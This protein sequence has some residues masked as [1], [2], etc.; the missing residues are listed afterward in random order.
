[1]VL[2]F[3]EKELAFVKLVLEAEGYDDNLKGWILDTMQGENEDEEES[4]YAGAAD[5]VIN[6]VS[7]F[8]KDNPD[9]IRA[10][11]NLVGNLLKR[12]MRKG[13]QS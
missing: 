11:G 13:P 1:M 9:T 4:R 10:A 3:T 8:V 2:T 6:N 5:R 7:E 12:T